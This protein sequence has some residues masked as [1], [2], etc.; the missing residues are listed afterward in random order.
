MLAIRETTA[1]ANLLGPATQ[2]TAAPLLV[3]SAVNAASLTPG[4]IAPGMLM[5]LLGAGPTV[6]EVFVQH[7][8]RADSFE[9][10]H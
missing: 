1:S 5:A 4:P 3:V 10:A 6:T 8:P 9:H 2:T 7:H